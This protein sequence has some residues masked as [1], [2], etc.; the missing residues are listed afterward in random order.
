MARMKASKR[1]SDKI[2]K[3]SCNLKAATSKILDAAN[4]SLVLTDIN[5]KYTYVNKTFEARTGYSSRE[6]IGKTARE[7]NIFA[8]DGQYQK[9]H[10]EIAEKGFVR[11]MEMLIRVKTGEIR[12]CLMSLEV[13]KEGNDVLV[14]GTASDITKHKM[15]QEALLES[16]GKLRALIDAATESV[17][18]INVDG[19]IVTSNET[20]AQRIKKMLDELIGR[21][22]YD[23][24]PFDVGERRKKWVQQVVRSKQPAIFED[25][26][27]GHFIEH[28]VYPVL[29][30][31]NKVSMI[32]V[33]A[34]DITTR[35][36]DEERLKE[37][38]ER[39]R[40]I[41]DGAPI[42]IN[43]LRKGVTLYANRSS[44]DMFGYAHESEMVGKSMLNEIAAH[45]REDIWDRA[46][47]HEKGEGIV[48]HYET[49]GLR[50][51][52]SEFPMQVTVSRTQLPDGPAS[53]IFLVDLTSRKLMEDELFKLRNIESIG[54]LA[55][56][57]AHDF[58][59][60]LMG[61]TGYIEL[62]KMLV[63]SENRAC[64]LLA[65][66]EKIAGQG[67]DLTQQLITF[68][69]GGE[70]IKRAIKAA[71]V[72]KDVS[73]FT[74]TGSNVKCEYFLQDDLYII[75]VDESQFR[76]VV[77]NI[78]LN[79]KEAMPGGGII[80]IRAGNI[81]I[82][83]GDAFPLSP[84][85]YVQI[86]IADKGTGIA[87]EN[88]PKIFDPY[89][90]TKDMGIQKGMGLGL[91]ISYSII[92]RHNGHIAVEPL[93]HIGT[94]FQIY[95]PAYSKKA[96]PVEKG[97]GV[98]PD[99]KRILFMDDEAF[100]RNIG[101]EILTHIGYDV[102]LAQ[103]GNET[104]LL[105]KQARRSGRHFDCVILDLTMKGGIGGKEVLREILSI[106]PEAK[107]IISSG[108]TDDP[109]LSNYASFGFKGV[110]TKPY[111][112]DELRE[113]LREVLL[114]KK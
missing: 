35:K 84:G 9:L 113:V 88:I 29:N 41:V 50:K 47:R 32:A 52:G 108:Y 1:T 92:R 112:I 111:N 37:S 71:S 27:E 33:F 94:S 13:V 63:P 3:V 76:Q 54:T 82:K 106:D 19:T 100:I 102:K 31:K 80:T 48:R 53:I 11:E 70:P 59:N 56:G 99:K 109:V 55:G 4:V 14:V 67:K 93:P 81:V 2:G 45:C 5:G 25:E 79:A 26:R 114:K 90:S 58:N 75:E 22:I 68:S 66:A 96:A 110:I 97:E 95:L 51:D 98:A 65:E 16:E 61:V 77:H 6:V 17:L 15:A 69:K 73:R 18:L 64:S 74:L 43:I 89:F 12:N 20:T 49:T 40:A 103:D 34:R 62:A 38:E 30:S 46:V 83:E 8:D 39:L 91:A 7:L 42:G 86:A 87:Q 85:N 78:V 104:V 23:C 101:H 28:S 57:I 21:S 105:Y 10:E 36:R 60:L 24:I 72:L 44:L 107:A